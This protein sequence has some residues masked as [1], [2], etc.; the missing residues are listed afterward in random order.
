[1]R[2]Y[3]PEFIRNVA[4]VAHGGAGKTTLVEAMLFTANVTTRMGRVEDG[5]TVSDYDPDEA[6]RRMSISS[7][8]APLE[9]RDTKINLIDTPGYSDFVGEL[10]SA[11]RV[12]DSALIVVDASSPVEVGT[13]LAWK[14]AT[15]RG[16]ARMIYVNKLSRENADFERTI[17]ALRSQF[18][19]SVVAVQFPIGTEKDFN[20]VIDLLREESHTLAENGSASEMVGPVPDDLK[21]K[22]AEY[23]R[24]LVEVIAEQ[25]ETLMVRYLEDDPIAL[26]ELWPVLRK[27]VLKG[28]ITPMFC[29]SATVNI[30]T[31]LLLD[32]IV[33]MAPWAGRSELNDEPL[34]ALIFKTIA[35]PHVGRVSLF[36]VYGGA[37]KANSH[38]QNTTQNQ[39]ERVG[40]VFYVRGKDHVAADFIG[41][42]DIG[43]VAKLAHSAT[44]DTLASDGSST[45]L[46]SI[47]FPHASYA[48]AVRP[49]SKADLDKLGQS[50][51]RLVEEDPSLHLSR[52]PITGESILSGM[53]ESHVQIALDRMSRRFGV[54]VDTGL[55]R[56]A[57]R[58]TVGSKINCEYKHKKQTG[59]AGQYGHVFLEIEPLAEEEFVFADRVVGGSVPKNFFPAV[60]KGVREALESGPLA[61]YPVVNIK[62]TLTDGSYH[63]VDSNEMAFKIAA[64]E[65]F[66]KGVLNARPALLEPVMVI[67]VKVPDYCAG[68]VMSDLNTKRAHVNGMDPADGWTVIEASVPAAEVQRYAT[69]LRS[70]TQGRGSF[71]TEFSHYQQVP[72]MVAEAIKAAS[73]NAGVA[74]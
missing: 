44:G 20:G 32:D 21:E 49:H 59:G 67:K 56:V 68:D 16:L 2:H 34:A 43:A 6:R 33:E 66:K 17:D 55:P 74:A 58:E 30:G 3:A 13:E 36:R 1:V 40:Q 48:A 23:R 61:G 28:I 25:D 52:D 47:V 42:G 62:V 8:V 50:L 27:A 19:K 64:K 57:Y 38:L 70:I 51:H 41:A 14:L 37:L 72:P 7:A 15:E 22:V 46:D 12:A 31:H 10:H 9:W 39:G 26:E 24:Q 45:Q 5:N 60:E 54:S 65:A 11:L 71:T 29:G 35:D 18:G 69:D 63:D 4:V 73:Q 53:G